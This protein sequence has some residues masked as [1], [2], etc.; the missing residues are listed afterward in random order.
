MEP[1]IFYLYQVFFFFLFLFFLIYSVLFYFI[2]SSL[3]ERKRTVIPSW[4]TLLFWVFLYFYHLTE[5]KGDD[6]E[7]R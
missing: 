3:M 7:R 5:L 6:D 1:G 2:F 4:S